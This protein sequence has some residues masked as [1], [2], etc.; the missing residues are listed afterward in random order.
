MDGGS[1]AALRPGLGVGELGPELGDLV[2]ALR[3]L[4][5]V[6]LERLEDRDRLG[7]L[8]LGQGK[9]VGERGDLGG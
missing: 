3:Q 1:G 5:A 7:D 2:A 4:G 6:L 8:L 9:L